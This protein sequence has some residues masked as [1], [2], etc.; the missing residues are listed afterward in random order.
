[1][2]AGARG[3]HLMRPPA[4]ETAVGERSCFSRQC[5]IHCKL[6]VI[7]SQSSTHTHASMHAVASIQLRPLRQ[8]GRVTAYL[9]GQWRHP[10]PWRASRHRRGD[11]AHADCVIDTMHAFSPPSIIPRR[12]VG[13]ARRALIHESQIYVPSGLYVMPL[14][15]LQPT[16]M[17]IG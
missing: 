8:T 3:P 1:M 13:R 5:A 17:K 16:A 4:M 2:G 15:N 6:L 7:Y 10:P 12:A 14:S 11:A 9:R